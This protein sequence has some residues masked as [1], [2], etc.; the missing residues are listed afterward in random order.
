MGD[1]VCIKYVSCGIK[2]SR[3]SLWCFVSINFY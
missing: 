1:I 2:G 3:D